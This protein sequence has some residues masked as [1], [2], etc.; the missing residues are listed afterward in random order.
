MNHVMC[1]ESR[2]KLDVSQAL[3]DMTPHAGTSSNIIAMKN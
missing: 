2:R 3:P 1:T